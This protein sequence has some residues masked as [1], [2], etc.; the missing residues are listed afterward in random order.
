MKG[1][2]FCDF[3]K[4]AENTLASIRGFNIVASRGQITNGGYLLLI[5]TAHIACIGCFSAEQAQLISEL[6]DLV[7]DVVGEEY[8]SE[9][10][11]FEHGIIGQ[12][13]PHAHLH[14]IPA[15]FDM[16]DRIKKDFPD[17][18]IQAL[19]SFDQIHSLYRYHRKPY[20]FWSTPNGKL[21]VCWD[22]PAPPMYLRLVAAEIL[23]VPERGDWK[24]IDPDQDKKL[25]RQT[26][27][28][29]TPYFVP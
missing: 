19:R 26:I 2:T 5:P 25:L 11:I 7:E 1:C 3:S 4:I 14:L 13:I 17:C 16:T 10:T 23:G 22:P 15:A 29:L 28:R 6:S 27:E 8:D 9:V 12:T 20:L 21:M 18:R 24:E